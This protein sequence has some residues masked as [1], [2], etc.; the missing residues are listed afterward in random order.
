MNQQANEPMKQRSKEINEW[1]SEPMNQSSKEAV[2]QW[3]DEL[4]N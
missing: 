1:I 2:K 3:T 4:V